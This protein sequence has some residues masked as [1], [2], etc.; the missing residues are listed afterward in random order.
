MANALVEG[1]INAG[2]CRPEDIILSGKTRTRHLETY[3]KKGF[4]TTLD[5]EDVG[6]H[7]ESSRV[8]NTQLCSS[9]L[10]GRSC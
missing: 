7:H 10:A 2:I 6:K 3:E 9:L 1:F 5:N 8:V 4:R